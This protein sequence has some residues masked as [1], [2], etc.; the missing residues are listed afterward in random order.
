MEDK[1][2][3][4]KQAKLSGFSQLL[5]ES[6]TNEA[7]SG[8]TC[9]FLEKHP[10]GLQ[11]PVASGISLSTEVCFV[12]QGETDVSVRGITRLVAWEIAHQC[13]GGH[14]PVRFLRVIHA[15]DSEPP[16]TAADFYY[17]IGV[18]YRHY[19]TGGCNDSGGEGK[20]GARKMHALMLFLSQ[21][22]GITVNKYNTRPEEHRFMRYEL[23]KLLK[24]QHDE[25]SEMWRQKQQQQEGWPQ[26]QVGHLA[27]LT[28]EGL[29]HFVGCSHDEQLK[30]QAKQPLLVQDVETVPNYCSCGLGNEKTFPV[31][32][33][34]EGKC[35]LRR[36][37]EMLHNQS[38]TI[39][40]GGYKRKSTGYYLEH[41]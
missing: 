18:G 6:C 23:W 25:C 15:K 29:R 37:H 16:Y 40:L 27:K 10:L 9:A 12:G 22:Y 5:I 28:E 35:H 36:R 38:V 34:P 4:S 17:E 20:S 31:I 8:F 3:E 19:M 30:E 21:M 39:E 11:V 14:N 32:M 1:R 7:I 13:L 41:V 26:Y 2:R 33:H 24:Q